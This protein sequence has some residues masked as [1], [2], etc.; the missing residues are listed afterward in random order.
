MARPA[1]LNGYSI[2]EVAKIELELKTTNKI[3]RKLNVLEKE[4]LVF[5]SKYSKQI[6]DEKKK[7]KSELELGLVIDDAPVVTKKE[8]TV[9]DVERDKKVIE[10]ELQQLKEDNE[11]LLESNRRASKAIKEIEDKSINAK[12]DYERRIA[13]FK[14]KITELENR[15]IELVNEKQEIIRKADNKPNLE[16]QALKN[17]LAQKNTMLQEHQNTINKAAETNKIIR[18]ELEKQ[19]AQNI[20]LVAENAELKK[21]L[22]HKEELYQ[23]AKTEVEK[24]DDEVKIHIDALDIVKAH[25]VSLKTT[26]DEKDNEIQTLHVSIEG[27]QQE[28][29]NMTSNAVPVTE[30]VGQLSMELAFYKDHAHKYYNQLK[31]AN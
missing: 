9:I 20:D 24:L 19:E 1:K 3:V 12:N 26:L 11:R 7:L 6:M 25:N 4:Y 13:T 16:I 22:E 31:G 21:Q 5:R 29:Q 28:I 8:T 10:Q 27:Y 23:N 14:S 17:E 15:N 2:K 18:A 30:D